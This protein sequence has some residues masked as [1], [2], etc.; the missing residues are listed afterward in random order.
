MS[1]ES[2]KKYLINCIN[3]LGDEEVIS[4]KKDLKNASRYH[5]LKEALKYYIF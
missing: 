5:D 1:F 2:L 4:L 3:T